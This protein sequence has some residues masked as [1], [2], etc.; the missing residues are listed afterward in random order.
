[1]K[2]GPALS[3]HR[4]RRRL[5][6]AK[7][8]CIG[9]LVVAVAVFSAPLA[10]SAA[11]AGR[12]ASAQHCHNV[13]GSVHTP[14]AR[15]GYTYVVT[16][17]LLPTCTFSYSHPTLVSVASLTDGAQQAETSVP[18]DPEATSHYRLWSGSNAELNATAVVVTWTI[19]SNG[20]QNL[21]ASASKTLHWT[22]SAGWW[23]TLNT[24]E[25][26]DGCVGDCGSITAHGGFEF[27]FLPTCL[28]YPLC[29]QTNDSGSDLTASADGLYQGCSSTWKWSLSDPGWHAQ[30]WCE[31]GYSG[32]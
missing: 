23:N 2:T 7:R 31:M 12:T 13:S 20:H 10:L 21:I 3:N 5:T 18:G 6:T 16:A 17:T 29:S 27:V 28:P 11:A 9:G 14:T 25:W 8:A 4:T 32:L 30:W 24:S 15:G 26:T 1:M 22:N 19:R